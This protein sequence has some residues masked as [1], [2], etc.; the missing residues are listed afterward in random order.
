MNFMAMRAG[1]DVR[2]KRFLANRL[3]DTPVSGDSIEK[4]SGIFCVPMHEGSSPRDG[5]LKNETIERQLF[6]LS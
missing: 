4:M 3:F 1:K 5:K 6:L 2:E